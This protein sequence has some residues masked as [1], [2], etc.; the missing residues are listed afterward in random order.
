MLKATKLGKVD[1]V[2]VAQKSLRDNALADSIEVNYQEACRFFIC[3]GMQLFSLGSLFSR[4]P[5]A[6]LG[7]DIS[8]SSVKL[9]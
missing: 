6:M 9:S 1:Q 4:Q 2:M 7:L 3:K 5:A 8:S